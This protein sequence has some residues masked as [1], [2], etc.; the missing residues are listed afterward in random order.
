MLNNSGMSSHTSR[1]RDSEARFIDTYTS[2]TT[3]KFAYICT[4][5]GKMTLCGYAHR[6]VGVDSMYSTYS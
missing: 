1:R 4:P 6:N 5:P 3:P 2:T